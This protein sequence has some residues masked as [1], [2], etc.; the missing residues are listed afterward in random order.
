M[1]W[2]VIATYNFPSEAFLA[3]AILESESIPVL[4]EDDHIIHANPLYANAV[5]G[6]KLKVLKTDS[7]QALTILSRTDAVQTIDDPTII[8]SEQLAC[9]N[10]GSYKLTESMHPFSNIHDIIKDGLPSF[11][12]MKYFKCSKCQ[13]QWQL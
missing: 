1:D 9:A 12:R 10:C 6:I 3:K 2:V 7:Q 8:E 11:I 4:M 13:H 5:G